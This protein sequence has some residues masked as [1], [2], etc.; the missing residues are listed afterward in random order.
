MAMQIG[1]RKGMGMQMKIILIL[2]LVNVSFCH[3]SIQKEPES[4]PKKQ[5]EAILEKLYQKNPQVILNFMIEDL[6]LHQEN[7]KIYFRETAWRREADF[8]E[9]FW[10]FLKGAQIA[11]ENIDRYINDEKLVGNSERRIWKFK[12]S[13]FMSDV[14]FLNDIVEQ[15]DIKPAFEYID[16]YEK[17]RH[18]FGPGGFDSDF[19]RWVKLR[20]EEIH[21]DRK[22]YL[23]ILAEFIRVPTYGRAEDRFIEAAVED[24]R[25][26]QALVKRKEHERSLYHDTLNLK[27]VEH[28]RKYRNLEENGIFLAALHS[29]DVDLFIWALQEIKKKQLKNFYDEIMKIY[30]TRLWNSSN[31]HKAFPY[32]P[33]EQLGPFRSFC[34]EKILPGHPLKEGF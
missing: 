15:V 27:A 11:S 13:M 19:V 9:Y 6:K 32:L 5:F 18:D 12:A 7:P 1:F 2:L 25:F 34:G 28:L 31:C 30:N 22:R 29:E 8:K 16:A 14:S 21:G 23:D 24:D 33:F 10:D 3:R 20:R 26:Y 17:R 4:E